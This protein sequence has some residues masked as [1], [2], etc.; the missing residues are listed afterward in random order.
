[1]VEYAL[2]AGFVAVAAGAAIP[3]GA[4]PTIRAIF[5]AVED[6]LARVIGLS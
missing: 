2:I 6:H 4:A 1:M 5:Q 3:Y